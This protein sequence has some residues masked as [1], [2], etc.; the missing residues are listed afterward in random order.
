ML[1]T[2]FTHILSRIEW[3][4]FMDHLITHFDR[5]GV[6]LLAPVALLHHLRDPLLRLQNGL[7]VTLYCQRKQAIDVAAVRTLLT[8]W[9]HISV[10]IPSSSHIPPHLSVSAPDSGSVNTSRIEMTSMAPLSSLSPGGG[11]AGRGYPPYIIKAGESTRTR[12]TGVVANGSNTEGPGPAPDTRPIN[13]S[14]ST[15]GSGLGVGQRLFTSISEHPST[16]VGEIRTDHHD[17]HRHAEELLERRQMLSQLEAQAAQVAADHHKWLQRHQEKM[18]EEQLLH[19]ARTRAEKEHLA[20]L[21]QLEDQ[22]TATTYP[23]PPL[24]PFLYLP[25]LLHPHSLYLLLPLSVYS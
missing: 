7:A 8:S 17:D 21:S 22:V 20:R 11:V 19:E 15:L 13:T 25:L 5:K 24:L 18:E 9:L 14:A 6:S 1:S 12:A 16:T 3:L 23:P 10:P 2:M 4:A